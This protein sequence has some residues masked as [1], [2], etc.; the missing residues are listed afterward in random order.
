MHD[1]KPKLYTSKGP[2]MLQDSTGSVIISNDNDIPMRDVESKLFS[3]TV[4]I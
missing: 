1:G 4:K 3:H 2:S